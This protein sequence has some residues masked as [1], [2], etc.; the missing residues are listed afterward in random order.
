M[1]AGY[2]S[3]VIGLPE[4]YEPLT[5]K[6]S[7]FTNKAFNTSKSFKKRVKGKI[8]RFAK[9][10]FRH[11]SYL[12]FI[13]ILMIIQL[14]GVPISIIL[15]FWIFLLFS[16]IAKEIYGFQLVV[17]KNLILKRYSRVEDKIKQNF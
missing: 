7:C 3:N 15:T 5:V 12:F 9:Q 6:R 14:L 17:F 13:S 11:V 1:S 10:F 4:N 8:L 2:A 16:V